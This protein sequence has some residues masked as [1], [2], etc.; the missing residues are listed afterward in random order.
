MAGRTTRSLRTWK[1]RA[2]AASIAGT[3][4]LALAACGGGGGFDDGGGGGATEGSDN[5]PLTVLIGSSGDAETQTMTSL[6]QAFTDETGIQAN[7]RNATNLP[8]ELAQGFA[9]GSPPDLFYVSPEQFPGWA[10][11]G[12]LYAYGDQ[13]D[14]TFHDTLKQTFT[15]DGKFFCAP[16]DFSTLA[17]VVNTTAWT[18]AG[19]TDADY[20]KTWDDLKAVAQKL[21]TGTQVGLSF[22][23]EWARI[24]AFMAQAGGHMLDADGHADVDTPEN[25]AAL[26]YVK[27]LLTSGVAAKPSQ[28]DSGWGGEAFGS[29][30][31]AMTIEGNWI[32]GAMRADFPTVQYKVVPLPEGPGGKGTL[33]FTNCYGIAADSDHKEAAVRLANFLTS[34]EQQMEAAR[35]FG[36]MPAVDTVADQWAEENPDQKAFV[37]GAEYAQGVAPIEGWTDVITDFNAQLEGLT[38]ADPQAILTSVQSSLAAIAP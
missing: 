7:L 34:D 4:A 32:V 3:A 17:L 20:P 2:V 18:A 13:L 9:A 33:Q 21:T 22:G 25:L 37:D 15:F 35:G 12:S 19:L 16:K 6:L 27:D 28:V 14:A 23:P 26:T 8:Q 5:G 31:A 30:R 1:G 29:Q 11:N 38:T 24:G 36:V 10:S